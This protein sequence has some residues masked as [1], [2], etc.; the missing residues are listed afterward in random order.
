MYNLT[1]KIITAPVSIYDLQRCVPVTLR[2][3]NTSTGE[4]EQA[5]SND[6]G[7]LCSA[8]VGQTIPSQD[9]HGNWTVFSRVPINMWAR[10]KPI[11]YASVI[12]LTSAQWNAQRHGVDRSSV[13]PLLDTN[14]RLNHDVW[15]YSRP[16]GGIASPYRMTDFVRYYHFAPCPLS[17]IFP[18]DNIT[19]DSGSAQETIGF[20]ITFE[21]GIGTWR[22]DD[23]CLY[24]RDIFYNNSSLSRYLTVGLIHYITGNYVG[25]F[26]SAANP[27]S[28]YVA[29][30]T[31]SSH[32]AGAPV[33]NVLIDLA[34]FKSAISAVDSTYLANGTKWQAV[35]FLSDTQLNGAGPLTTGTTEL[36][37]YDP[38]VAQDEDGYEEGCDRHVMTISRV[39][40]SGSITSMEVTTTY[41]KDGSSQYK[42]SQVVLRVERETNLPAWGFDITCEAICVGGVMSNSNSQSSGEFVP[43]GT[44]YMSFPAGE[45]SASVTLNSSN[46]TGYY[47]QFRALG[48]GN[49]CRAILRCSIVRDGGEKSLATD[50][51][52]SGGSSEYIIKN[53]ND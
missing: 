8:I 1:T 51:D 41:T 35:M 9:G 3:T 49:I 36:L 5:S 44:H 2:R 37:Q 20:T 19:I 33:C 39:S 26:K 48:A 24:M 34:D 53:P 46:F 25:F 42:I 32:L 14:G 38:A 18:G 4:V 31:D 23:C 43:S 11:L 6:L 52:C 29:S 17:I 12:P 15:T 13:L 22:S 45:T 28:S 21:Q 47:Y 10:Y 16:T 40:W 7:V 27:L 50:C 30:R